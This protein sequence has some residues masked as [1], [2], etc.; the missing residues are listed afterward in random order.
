MSVQNT[1]Q[2]VDQVEMIRASGI[3]PEPISWIWPSW[4]ARGK[5]AILA[6]TPGTGIDTRVEVQS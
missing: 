1:Q 5:L 2:F 4:L 6:G 3:T